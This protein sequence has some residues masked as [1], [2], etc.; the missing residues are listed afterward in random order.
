LRTPGA[1]L[2]YFSPRRFDECALIGPDLTMGA[3]RLGGFNA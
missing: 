1:G 2:V 3:Q